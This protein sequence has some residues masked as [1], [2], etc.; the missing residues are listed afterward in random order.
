MVP[1]ADGYTT[2]FCRT[3]V[4]LCCSGTCMERRGRRTLR[5]VDLANREK[6]QLPL[7]RSAF[8]F[9]GST[10]QADRVML[11]SHTAYGL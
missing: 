11:S 9:S 3:A 8:Q 7:R 4:A 10:Y 1:I 2:A 5:C 6:A